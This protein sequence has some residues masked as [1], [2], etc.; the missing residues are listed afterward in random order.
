MDLPVPAGHQATELWQR[1]LSS[2]SRG[3]GAVD[4][5]QDAVG[6]N[7]PHI[8]LI[9]SSRITKLS[10]R[11]TIALTKVT[12][13]HCSI[14]H[15]RSLSWVE[16]KSQEFQHQ[17][18]YSGWGLESTLDAARFGEVTD[19]VAATCHGLGWRLALLEWKQSTLLQTVLATSHFRIEK[20]YKV[21]IFLYKKAQIIF[22]SKVFWE[23]VKIFYDFKFIS[24]H[25]TKT[26]MQSRYTKEFKVSKYTMLTG[27]C[28]YKSVLNNFHFPFSY[29]IQCIT[30]II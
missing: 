11:K 26:M 16:G 24:C 29:I 21:F 30:K 10:I 27:S 14:G 15:E 28:F 17:A 8:F 13:F 3:N 22:V 20:E 6:R 7:N 2:P 4:I 1:H 12:Q 18:A 25:Q 5:H 9:F 23:T 19:M